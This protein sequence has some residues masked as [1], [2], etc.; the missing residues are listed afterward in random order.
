MMAES[1]LIGVELHS[2]IGYDSLHR[3]SLKDPGLSH[4]M[5]CLELVLQF[6]SPTQIGTL[7]TETSV[8]VILQLDLAEGGQAICSSLKLN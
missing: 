7:L 3:S 6:E 5:D 8:R 4:D 2:M 1:L